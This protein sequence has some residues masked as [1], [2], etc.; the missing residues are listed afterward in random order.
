MRRSR[1]SYPDAI[2]DRVGV[3]VVRRRTSGTAVGSRAR[4]ACQ[5]DH[6]NP[7]DDYHSICTALGWSLRGSRTDL[8]H[9]SG[10]QGIEARSDPR[11][12]KELTAMNLKRFVPT[13]TLTMALDNVR[14]H[15]F[16]SFLTVL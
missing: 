12:F 13:E 2:P 3:A 6:S 16:R 5:G 9:I 14:A 8:R 1:Q 15:K 4:L 7:D 10:L 11:A